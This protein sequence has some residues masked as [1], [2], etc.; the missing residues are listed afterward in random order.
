LVSTL[1]AKRFLAVDLI[2]D[3]GISPI[4][5]F[6]RGLCLLAYMGLQLTNKGV[7][8]CVGLVIFGRA[9]RICRY[10]Y[11]KKKKTCQLHVQ[12]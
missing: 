2:V 9:L 6:R 3:E 10:R 4:V 12:F 1:K 5:L 7:A 8:P 11:A